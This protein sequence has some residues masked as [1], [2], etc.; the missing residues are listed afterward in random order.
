[1]NYNWFQ[2]LVALH[3]S[4]ICIQGNHPPP[5]INIFHWCRFV[6]M[7]MRHRLSPACNW[8]FSHWSLC[9]YHQLSE[10]LRVAS[11]GR[12]WSAHPLPN[13]FNVRGWIH[14]FIIK[15]V[16]ISLKFNCEDLIWGAIKTLDA[17]NEWYCYSVDPQCKRITSSN[18]TA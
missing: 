18:D 3:S 9:H 10:V 2:P 17:V 8:L 16:T 6:R 1:M 15:A 4:I 7:L 5:T 14:P 13:R 11:S 12:H